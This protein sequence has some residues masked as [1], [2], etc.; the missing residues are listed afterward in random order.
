[1]PDDQAVVVS[2]IPHHPA[3]Q[4][5]LIDFLRNDAGAVQCFGK[6]RKGEKLSRFVNIGQGAD[7]KRV[8]CANETLGVLVPARESEIAEDLVQSGRSGAFQHRQ[9][10]RV[11][12]FRRI[13]AQPACKRNGLV[14]PHIG[15][16][17]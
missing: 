2:Q 1:M 17:D 4:G 6:G 10:Q 16:H 3:R 14:E 12:G 13:A 5:I 9:K 11:L 8:A 7:A 15:S